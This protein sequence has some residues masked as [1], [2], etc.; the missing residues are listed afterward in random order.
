MSSQ[1]TCVFYLCGEPLT[2]KQAQR[3]EY[4]SARGERGHG[5]YCCN[6]CSTRDRKR[7]VR[8][9]AKSQGEVAWR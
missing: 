8:A 5:P 3:W 2:K 4:R 6:E 7:I 9:Y 1:L